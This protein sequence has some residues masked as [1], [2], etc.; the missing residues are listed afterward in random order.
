MILSRSVLHSQ[1][2]LCFV[3]LSPDGIYVLVDPE[4]PIPH[5]LCDRVISGETLDLMDGRW[6]IGGA[7]PIHFTN[8]LQNKKYR[9]RSLC[10]KGQGVSN[11]SLGKRGTLYTLIRSMG[12][13]WC[14]CRFIHVY[15]SKAGKAPQ[16]SS[17]PKKETPTPKP[18]PVTFAIKELVYAYDKRKSGGVLY[19]AQVIK[20]RTDAL[21]DLEYWV[22]YKGY[23]KSHS[24]WLPSKEILK[25][26]KLNRVMYLKS[27]SQSSKQSVKTNIIDNRRKQYAKTKAQKSMVRKCSKKRDRCSGSGIASENVESKRKRQSS[28]TRRSARCAQTFEAMEKVFAPDKKRSG[29]ILYEATI[30]KVKED[31]TGC[32]KYLVQYK[33]FKKSSNQLLDAEDLLKQTKQNRLRFEKSRM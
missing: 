19:E 8:S 23:K 22:H 30:L 21:D 24:K 27:R 15:N 32:L 31:A 1:F 9:K 17:L 3:C 20:I 12:E 29:D 16:V 13:D 10:P 26:N 11:A 2:W 5:T 25:Q 14:D 33:G 28:P 7:Q 6:S 4:F 18:R